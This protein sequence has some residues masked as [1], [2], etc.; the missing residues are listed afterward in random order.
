MKRKLFPALLAACAQL[1]AASSFAER[2]N[3]TL[4]VQLV[5]SANKV[6]EPI[7]KSGSSVIILDQE[8][9]KRAQKQTV[10][11]ILRTVPGL[12]VVTSGGQGG[13]T[14]IFMRGANSEHTLVLL[15]GIE[16][17]NPSSTSRL[18]NFANLSLNNVEKIE[19]V[20]GA[21]GSLY[22]SDAVGGVISIF[23]KEPELGSNNN[24]ILSSEA[25]SQYSFNN[26][27]LTALNSERS[28]LQLYAE[29]RD[30]EGF[31]AQSNPET[32]SEKD[33]YD[34]S[35]FSNDYR[36]KIDPTTQLRL[37]N[38]YTKSHADLD[39][40]TGYIPDDPNRRLTTSEL[41][42]RIEAS[43]KT[44][45]LN[46]RAGASYTRQTL[47]DQDSADQFHPSDIIDS[48]Y[49]G[50]M[51][52]F[53]YF[54]ESKLWDQSS[55][56]IGLETEQEAADSDNFFSSDFGDFTENFHPDSVRTKSAYSQLR[57]QITDDFSSTQGLR[58]DSHDLAG[59][60]VTYKIAP[61]LEITDQT[62]LRASY[63][64]GFKAP[65]L[66]QLYS[67]YGS[68][69][70]EAE[71]SRNWEIGLRHSTSSKKSSYDLSYFNNR[72][73]N[74]IDFNPQTFIF[75]NVRS[76]AISGVSISAKHDL[77]RT[78]S[79]SLSY[80]YLDTEDRETSA[81]LLRRARHRISNIST[82]NA[83]QSLSFNNELVLVG[84]R[85]DNDFSSFPAERKTLPSYLI[86]NLGAR[87]SYSEDLTLKFRI[88]NLFDRNY[89]DVIGYNVPGLLM[90]AG[91][92]L[93]L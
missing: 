9:I 38:Q 48:N 83:N 31:S 10:A 40:G 51:L 87:Y 35:V 58:F 14:S 75:D 23:T 47:Q 52:K 42:S 46:Q 92:D 34:S 73:S 7:E 79:N 17:N 5:V 88:E 62:N 72:I 36:L 19:I 45:Q 91:F 4:P 90:F 54:L 22:G 8:E 6:E 24:L 2:Q 64:T 84:N 69:D 18:Y 70:L 1:C 80:T 3:E 59:D 63:A 60:E 93:T 55:I 86:V 71:E 16:L 76:A 44:S 82:F 13:N 39:D 21:S 26:N 56:L 77:H 37:F 74:L 33:G 20:F 66:Y 32:S 50:R 53:D 68:Q 65:S 43:S 89:Q 61:V 27:I 41:L 11:E 57:L 12:D 81:E 29:R 85:D 15:N 30:S 49:S 25:G 67:V 78:F 28:S